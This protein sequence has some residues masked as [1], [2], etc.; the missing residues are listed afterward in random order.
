MERSKVSRRQFGVQAVAASLTGAA[1]KAGGGIPQAEPTDLAPE[2]T[3]EVEARLAEAVRR[4]GDRLSEAQRERLRGVLTRNVRMLSAIRSFPL[5]N[6]DTP[7][8]SLKL[9]SEKATGDHACSK[10]ADHAE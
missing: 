3:A 6:G 7:A 4:Y 2:Q 5:E 1:A 10:V 8:M 9:S